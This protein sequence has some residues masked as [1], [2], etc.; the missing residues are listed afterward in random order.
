MSEHV[1]KCLNIEEY[2]QICPNP[3]HVLI[4][5]PGLLHCIVSQF[6]EVY[7][8]KELFSPK[9]FVFLKKNFFIVAGSIWFVFCFLFLLP[10]LEKICDIR[11]S[12]FP[13]NDCYLKVVSIYNCNIQSQRLRSHL[14][15]LF[16]FFCSSCFWLHLT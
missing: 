5:I 15:N 2:F 1:W 6:N 14:S 12:F 9:E 11:M 4:V 3:L 10:W 8:L 7:S 13:T 16:F